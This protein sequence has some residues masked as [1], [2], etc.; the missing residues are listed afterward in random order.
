MPL[1]WT[2]ELKTGIDDIDS[3]HKE[4]FKRINMLRDAAKE[5][6]GRQAIDEVYEFLGKYI[7][8]H[9]STEESLMN[10]YAYPQIDSHVSQHKHFIEQYQKLKKELQTSS[11]KLLAFI[12]TN[13]LLG[14][15]WLD[16]N[17]LLICV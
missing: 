6:K 1:V 14:K 2:D 7:S 5:G 17:R 3:Q 4:L 11:Q 10:Q 13:A 8:E 12:E 16:H 9:F 15:W